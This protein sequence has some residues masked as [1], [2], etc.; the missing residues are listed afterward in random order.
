MRVIAENPNFQKCKFDSTANTTVMKKLLQTL[1]FACTFT[2][3]RA[4]FV[5]STVWTDFS[6]TYSLTAG[7]STTTQAGFLFC[8]FQPQLNLGGYPW[9]PQNLNIFL[10]GFG[11]SSIWTGYKLYE[12]SGGN[13][14]GSLSQVMNGSGVSMTEVYYAQNPTNVRYV[15]AG[16]YNNGCY[17]IGLNQWGGV[18][19]TKLYPFPQN[20]SLSS[21]QVSKPVLVQDEKSTDFYIAGSA[22]GK[23]YVNRVTIS[24]NLVW[25]N[26]YNCGGDAQPNAI[27]MYNNG[28]SRV[29]IAGKVEVGPNDNDAILLD[30]DGAT[31]NVNTAL[32]FGQPQQ[33]EVFNTVLAT[34]TVM[35]GSSMDIILG[36]VY[37]SPGQSSESWIVRLDPSLN[38]QWSNLMQPASGTNFGIVDM[39]ERVNTSGSAEY[40]ALVYSPG[41]MLVLKLDNMCSPSGL[42]ATQTGNEFLYNL[43]GSTNSRPAAITKVNGPPASMGAGIQVYGTANNITTAATAHMVQAYFNGETNCNKTFYVQNSPIPAGVNITMQPIAIGSGLNACSTFT[44]LVFYTGGAIN[45]PCTGFMT[46]GDNARTIATAVAE[47]DKQSVNF[48]VSPNPVSTAATITFDA[49][50]GQNAEIA[51][52]DISGRVLETVSISCNYSGTFEHRI[53]VAQMQLASGVYFAD[54]K[55]GNGALRQKFIVTASN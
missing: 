16:A 52:T 7:L 21:S 37:Q 23:M 44:A 29:L 28:T 50:E 48:G 11:P 30:I 2:A 4:Q 20:I 42:S 6:P 12:G 9:A 3:L 55:T 18:V 38:M 34:T 51:I 26:S 31:G 53:D 1:I 27:T 8:G 5:Y 49:Q 35:P 25:S 13:C 14:S 46:S 10:R 15:I 40:Y 24:G 43:A 41:G 39:I 19:A 36:G 22:A 54:L 17:F 45:F 33:N 32:T 47:I